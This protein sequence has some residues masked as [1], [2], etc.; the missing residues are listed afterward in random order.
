LD[1]LVERSDVDA[2]IICTP[3]AE[4]H[5]QSRLCLKRGWHVLCEKPLAST[6]EQIIELIADAK[7]ARAKGQIFSLGY[8]RRYW[9][10]F[11]TLRREVL[12][13]RWGRV[14]AIASHNVENWQ[15]TI[16]GTWRD[17]P[18]QNPG[19][20]VTDAGSHKL[21]AIFYI[22]GLKPTEVFARSQKWNSHVEI[23][24][25]VSAQLGSEVALTMDFIGNAQ[26]L[27]EDLHIHCERAD[28]MLRH[29]ELWI[30][31]AGTR[32][33]LSADDPDSN[34]VSGFLDTILNGVTDLSPPEAALPV[35][36]MTQAIIASSRS[37]KPTQVE[38]C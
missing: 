26:E 3:T 28:L 27:S 11:R 6:R 20:F 37:G 9:S 38:P 21:D 30:A 22:T 14:R 34:P 15:S 18:D 19:G 25:S 2:A 32:R 5:K 33:K 24:T 29:N 12:S 36:E 4:H 7:S 16:G 23:V 1:A 13:N 31:E 35:Y 10:L 8:Q 17:D